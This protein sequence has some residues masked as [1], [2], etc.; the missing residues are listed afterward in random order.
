MTMNPLI[1]YEAAIARVA[2]LHHEA[3]VHRLARGAAA[4]SRRSRNHP[5]PAHVAGELLFRAGHRLTGER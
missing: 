3:A 4:D 1:T 5:T 2:D